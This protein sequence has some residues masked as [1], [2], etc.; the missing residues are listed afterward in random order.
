M[1]PTTVH[2]TGVEKTFADDQIIV[3]KTDPKGLLTYVNELFIEIS[4]YTEAELIGQPHNIIRH[5][6]MPRSVFKLLWD[7]ISSG[8]ELFAYVMNM[9]ADGSHYWVL[10]HV[11]PT[12]DGAGRIVGYH[13]NRR[14]ASRAALDRIKPLYAA[15]LAEERRQSSTPAAIEAGTQLLNRTLQEAGMDYDQFIWS[16]D[17]QEVAA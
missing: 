15:L 2:P 5:P 4:G 9:S 14:T 13:S 1:R 11:T 7:R 6:E 10:A 8:E 16:L 3:S 12:R 17:P